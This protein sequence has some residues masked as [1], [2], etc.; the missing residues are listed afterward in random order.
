MKFTRDTIVLN[1]ISKVE[2]N[3]IQIGE[4]IYSN[5]IGLLPD[6]IIDAWPVCPI[7]ELSEETLLPILESLPELLILGSGWKQKY[8]PREL[9]FSLA[10]RGIGLEVMD[11]PAACRTFNILV[12]EDRL[13]AAV[14]YLD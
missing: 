7:A 3:S 1:T 8:P 2:R 10:R 4:E 9:L 5:N 12:S 13:P 6:T 11:T 14:L